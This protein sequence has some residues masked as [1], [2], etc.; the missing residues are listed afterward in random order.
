MNISRQFSAL[1][2]AAVFLS[3]VAAAFAETRGTNFARMPVGCLKHVRIEDTNKGLIYVIE[4]YTGVKGG[5]HVVFSYPGP[6]QAGTFD[7]KRR[8]STSYYDA[9]G[10]LVRR[11]LANGVVEKFHPHECARISGRCTVVQSST[12]GPTHRLEAK[13]SR[14]GNRMHF[15]DVKLDGWA[16]GSFVYTFGPFGDIVASQQPGRRVE[17]IRYENCGV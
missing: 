17:L 10:L 6:A 9:N 14:R 1:A 5:Q 7:A 8:L 13:T 16:E 11:E 15:S 2:L 3:P 4:V 12:R